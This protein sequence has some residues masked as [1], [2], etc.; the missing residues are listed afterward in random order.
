MVRRLAPEA[1][2]AEIIARTRAMIATRG[3]EGL[4]LREVARWCGMTAP[5]LLHHFDGLAA[6]LE[7]VLEERAD[8][9]IH[10]Y[11]QAIGAIGEH[12]TLR[13]LADATVRVTAER[14][15]ESANFDRLEMIALM[16]RTHPL[17]EYY[18]HGK[19]I[20]RLR[21][22]TLALAERE[23]EDPLAVVSVLGLVAEGLRL[24][25]LRSEAIPDYE[26]DWAAV[27]DTVFAGFEHRRKDRPL[28]AR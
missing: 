6:V 25:W 28:T 14:R 16:D 22:L 13:D 27:R 11:A 4:S 26:A 8:E 18:R 23:Y 3:A 2:R 21:P 10:L 9:E 1:R 12:A 24:R 5:G 19:D 20:R 7:A 17:H 15:E